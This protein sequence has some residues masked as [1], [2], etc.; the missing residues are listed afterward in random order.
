MLH[1]DSLVYI[2]DTKRIFHPWASELPGVT[3]CRDVADIHDQ[4]IALGLEGRHRIR[5]ADDLGIDADPDQIGPRLLI[6]LEDRPLLGA[7]PRCPAWRP[8]RGPGCGN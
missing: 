8:R 3:Y 5:V 4:L 6:L 1:H 7:D 2:L